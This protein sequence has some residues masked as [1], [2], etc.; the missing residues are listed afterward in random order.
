MNKKVIVF[1]DNGYGEALIIDSTKYPSGF[2]IEAFCVDDAYINGRESFF[3]KR[4]V[5]FSKVLDVYPPDK[6]DMISVVDAPS[7]YRNRMIVFNKLK[8]AGYYLRNYVSPMAYICN[9]LI[10]GENNIIMPFSYAGHRGKI[11][12]ANILREFCFIGH[13]FEFGDGNILCPGTKIGGFS[14]IGNG[15]FLGLNV[16]IINFVKIDDETLIGAGSVVLSDTRKYTTIVGNPARVIAT[17]EKEGIIMKM[18]WGNE[19][20]PPPPITTTTELTGFVFAGAA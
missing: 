10:M 17:H 14:K 8:N 9:D 7:K 4:L 13:D 16:S 11:G 20:T 6:Y 15:C 5:S 12:N 18:K 2:E 19:E 1:G 3:G